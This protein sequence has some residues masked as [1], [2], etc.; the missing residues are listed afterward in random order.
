MK[1]LLSVVV[2]LVSLSNATMRI[3]KRRV[4]LKREM[5]G[6]EECLEQLNVAVCSSKAAMRTGKH[7]VGQIANEPGMAKQNWPG[8]LAG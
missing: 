8:K 5:A 3:G 6:G 1:H 7:G 2:V 4:L